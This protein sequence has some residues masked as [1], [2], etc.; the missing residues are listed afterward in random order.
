[1]SG[2]L[3]NPHLRME[4]EPPTEDELRDIFNDFSIDGILEKEDLGMTLRYLFQNPSEAELE[5][6]VNEFGNGAWVDFAGFADLISQKWK[7]IDTEL[8]LREAFRVFDRDGNGFLDAAELRNALA[9]NGEPLTAKELDEL[10]QNADI[11]G[12]G[13][14]NYDEFAKITMK[15]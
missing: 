4:V 13:K 14:I 15:G 7:K 11:D 9:R 6:W 1:M 12:D 2:H 10:F 8:E 3:I 5:D